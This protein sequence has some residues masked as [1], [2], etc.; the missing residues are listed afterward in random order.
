MEASQPVQGSNRNIIVIILV[1]VVLCCCCVVA[2]VGGYYGYQAYQA[3]RDTVETLPGFGEGDLPAGG[4]SDDVTRATAWGSMLFTGPIFDCATPTV[5]G[6]AIEVVQEPDSNGVWIER[7]D[8]ACGDGTTRPFT[9]T[10]SP[11]DG[12]TD[13]N[14]APPQ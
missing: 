9:I 2:G 12:Y 4:L 7:W 14:I 11:A 1:A 13:V 5:E 6:T 3:A 8:V 10:F